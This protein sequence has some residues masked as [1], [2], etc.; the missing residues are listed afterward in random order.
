MA[1]EVPFGK[2]S[3]TAPYVKDRPGWVPEG[4]KD[5]IAAYSVYQ[6]IYWSHVSTTYKVMNRGLDDADD[7]LYVPS[8]RIMVD[9]IN[10][11][12]A[13]DLRFEAV[14]ATGNTESQLRATAAFTALFARERFSSKY[15]ASKR[16]GLI[17]GDW[18]WHIVADPA[19][20]AGKRI[21]L[22]TVQADS[23]FPVFEDETVEGGDPEKMVMVVLAE[24]VQVGDET[25]VRTQRYIRTEQGI[26]S[27]ANLWKADEWFKWRF[28]DEVK[29]PVS[30][31]T[32]PSLLPAA[33][34]AFPVYHV[35]NTTETGEVFGSSEM[36]GLEVL[37]AALNQSMTDEDLS[38]ALLGLGLYATEEPGAPVGPDG[39]T[40][41]WFISPGA[42]L[43][44]AKGLHKVEGLT[45]LEPYTSHV[46]RI[47]GYMGDASGATDAAKG[48]IQVA[49]AESGIALQLRLAPTLAKAQEKDKIILDVHTQMFYDLTNM[50][51]P[52]IEQMNFS[53]VTVIP[54]LGDKLPVNR[55]A[56]AALANELVLG[57]ILSAASARKYLISKGFVGMFDPDEAELILAEKVALAAAE[58]GDSALDA[59]GNQ[60]TDP[61]T[62][63]TGGEDDA[64]A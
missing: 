7:P 36:R 44:N 51:F 5:R 20:E 3:S 14:S 31:L 22:L 6:E 27:E 1:T 53:D 35:P 56:E 25:L 47:E 28:D 34:T 9:T 11:Y 39:K 23:Y 49:E 60:E 59:R 55:V 61:G 17:K 50:W 10:R 45:S 57:G 16:D 54:V 43:E 63:D 15:A 41:P 52:A 29:Q 62:E 30:A 58:G 19:K 13:P 2:Y 24:Q 48:R 42:V 38:L 40:V 8:S 64:I 4:H 46:N 26:T 21:S 12:T 37:Q 32:P 33:I 18:L